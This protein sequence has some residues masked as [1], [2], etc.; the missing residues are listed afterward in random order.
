MMKCIKS[1][2]Q[3]QKMTFPANLHLPLKPSV[4]PRIAS[5]VDLLQRNHT[6]DPR[7][8]QNVPQRC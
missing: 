6:G 4:M 3:I 1:V 8:D 2:T 7:A 5:M